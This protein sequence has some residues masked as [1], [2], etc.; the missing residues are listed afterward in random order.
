MPEANA[1]P[2]WQQCCPPGAGSERH[3]HRANT[4]AEAGPYTGARGTSCTN[5][6]LHWC[7]WRT[8]HPPDGCTGAR[9]ASRTEPTV[10]L[11]PVATSGPSSS[12]G[13]AD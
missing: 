9:G 10:A 6:L 3:T 13:N 8:P 1:A 12:A 4:S 5:R 7:P 2:S 11:V